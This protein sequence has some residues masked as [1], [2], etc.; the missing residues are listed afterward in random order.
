MTINAIFDNM[1]A[2]FV[3]KYIAANMIG[4]TEAILICVANTFG[5]N[6]L[7]NIICPEKKIH[8]TILP[9]IKYI[10]VFIDRSLS[11]FLETCRP[12][13]KIPASEQYII[14]YL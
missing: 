10:V 1:N 3:R 4:I 13:T 12:T 5:N 14:Y 11:D 7:L 2:F 8:V 9:L 6:D